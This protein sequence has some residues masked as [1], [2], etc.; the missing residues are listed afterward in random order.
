MHTPSVHYCM[1]GPVGFRTRSRWERDVFSPSSVMIF[2][3]IISENES[4]YVGPTGSRVWPERKMKWRNLLVGQSSQVPLSDR[5]RS[6]TY[7]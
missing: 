6:V 2:E 1:L 3:E 4:M 7:L 5:C